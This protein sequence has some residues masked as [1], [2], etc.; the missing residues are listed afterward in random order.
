[1]TTTV[2]KVPR[3]LGWI[4]G[5]TL[6][7]PLSGSPG[8][9]AAD[10]AL[11]FEFKEL[12]GASHSLSQLRGHVVLLEFWAPWCVPCRKGFPF[13]DALEASHQAAGFRVVA[14]TME[15]DAESVREFVDSHPAKFL[16]GMDPSGAGAEMF[17]VAVMPTAVLLDQQGQILARFEGGTEA[18]HEQIQA[19]VDA[20]MSGAP[21]PI[22]ASAARRQGP[23]GN[24]RAWERGYLADPIMSL[25]GDPLNKSIREHIHAS[26][27]AAAGDGGISGGGCGCN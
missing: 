5:L 23:T 25:D 8:S 20:V 9:L 10:P 3:V 1:M 26:K 2:L 19:A 21:L 13:L 16:V 18:D 7:A 17:E 12:S 22:G 4:L 6:L 24:L 14:I 27:E 15:E 11:N